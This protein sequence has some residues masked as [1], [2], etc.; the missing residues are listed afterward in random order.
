MVFFG[1]IQG[2]IGK[3][4]MVM[5]ICSL[6]TCWQT[7]LDGD[8]LTK[9]VFI[10]A[11]INI[12]LAG[13]SGYVPFLLIGD[14][15]SFIKG[16]LQISVILGVMIG[17]PLFIIAISV[18]KKGIGTRIYYEERGGRVE[19]FSSEDADNYIELNGM[20]SE[21]FITKEEA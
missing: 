1:M 17:L 4:A 16:V 3:A 15:L 21:L 6:L 2:N 14:I 13:I 11:A 18:K 19:D 7:D 5:C 8:R 12:F 10:S 9:A 20:K